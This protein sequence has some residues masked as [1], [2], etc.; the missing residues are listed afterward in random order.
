MATQWLRLWHDMPNDPKI[1]RLSNSANIVAECAHAQA[2][3]RRTCYPN[4]RDVEKQCGLNQDE[5]LRAFDELCFSGVVF[6]G[7]PSLL[8]ALAE[9]WP[10]APMFGPIGSSRPCA[11][12][13]KLVRSRIFKRDDYCCRYCGARGV[14]LECDHVVPICQGGDHSDENLVAACFTCNRSKAGKTPEQ[15]R[16]T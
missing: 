8:V 10:L 3:S 2:E 1:Y 9:R 15:W 4:W 6:G 16:G 11:E 13:W 12:S 14:K 5:F 7:F